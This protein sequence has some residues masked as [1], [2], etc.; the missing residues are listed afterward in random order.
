MNM[1]RSLSFG[2]MQKINI[3]R[4]RNGKSISNAPVQKNK[5]ICFDKDALS[6][7]DTGNSCLSSTS[8]W[9]NDWR[10]N[11]P[12]ILCFNM[13]SLRS[14]Y[15]NLNRSSL[16]VKL[17]VVSLQLYQIQRLLKTIFTDFR[18]RGRTAIVQRC[19]AKCL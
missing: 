18:N 15:K 3:H 2:T 19:S 10:N 17:Q 9:G 6:S 16:L 1:W 11:Q 5:H 4:M 7:S 12:K 13:L 8:F 14:L